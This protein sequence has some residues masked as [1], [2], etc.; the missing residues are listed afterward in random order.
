MKVV[1]MQ[2]ELDED[3][4][5]EFNGYDRQGVVLTVLND[6]ELTAKALGE[7]QEAISTY[8]DYMESKNGRNK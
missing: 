5:V 8:T 2:F 4:I 3:V 1:Q 7:L 6:A